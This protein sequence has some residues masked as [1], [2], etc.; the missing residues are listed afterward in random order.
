LNGHKGRIHG[1]TAQG[2]PKPGLEKQAL[3]VPPQVEK[4]EFHVVEQQPIQLEKVEGL[5]P[6]A[7]GEVKPPTPAAELQGAGSAFK[8]TFKMLANRWNDS[9]TQPESTK[10]PEAY[11]ITDSEIEDLSTNLE[12]V[13][14][15]H[16]GDKGAVEFLSKYGAEIGL[17]VV[18]MFFVGKIVGG[19]RAKRKLQS[20]GGENPVE[21]KISIGERIANA[22]Q[23]KN[24]EGN[25]NITDRELEK[26]AGDEYKKY[27][28]G[29]PGS[30]VS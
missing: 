27:W 25:S 30:G 18:A 5:T 24:S 8:T 13:L 14:A 20:G 22:F 4:A 9:L 28:S 12:A 10:G 7:A 16:G 11:Q 19:L 21:T 29:V 1:G 2:Q 26:I 15:K 6:G 23:P 3:S 17:L